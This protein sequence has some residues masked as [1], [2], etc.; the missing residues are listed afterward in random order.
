MSRPSVVRAVTS[1]CMLF[2]AAPLASQ[3]SPSRVLDKPACETCAIHIGA[4]SVFVPDIGTTANSSGRI[5]GTAG[6]GRW[7]I[8]SGNGGPPDIYDAL[9]RHIGTVGR[10]GGG[11]GEFQSAIA[12][13]VGPGDSLAIVDPVNGRVHILDPMLR[14]V[15]AW[16]LPQNTVTGGMIWLA[17]KSQ[18]ALSGLRTTPA[19]IGFTV[20]LYSTA[21]AHLSSLADER[22]TI[23]RTTS[24]LES[25]RLLGLAGS[26]RLWT[27]SVAGQY[28]IQVWEMDGGRPLA[29]F[30][31]EA[32]WFERAEAMFRARVL[33]A[34]LDADGVLWTLSAA[35][36][37]EW[38]RG[39]RPR[40]IE[41]TEQSF[42]ILDRELIFDSVIEAIDLATGT[43]L[44]QVR[45]PRL[46]TSLLP[47]RL[48]AIES[49]DPSIG[50]GFDLHPVQLKRF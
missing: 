43:L 4:R 50:P 40:L 48:L 44:A 22:R 49:D 30:V 26:N 38:E 35:L 39:V 28:R 5:I 12:F 23:S 37:D 34:L 31:R 1:I 33:S 15:R 9:G 17:G 19:E 20:H 16:S 13:A 14:P 36:S 27:V 47:G 32:P 7:V 41:G 3:V 42:E 24:R 45:T 29:D 10:R 11:P 21:G 25:A 2:P 46:Y 6:R 18:L 8:G